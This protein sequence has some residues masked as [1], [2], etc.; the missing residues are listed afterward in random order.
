MTC[1]TCW[2][3]LGND[4]VH[5]CVIPKYEFENITITKDMIQADC[6]IKAVNC[7][8]ELR[9]EHYRGHLYFVYVTDEQR[10]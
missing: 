3:N 2:K 10:N 6:I 8:I 1:T 4:T 7:N 5:T 9:H